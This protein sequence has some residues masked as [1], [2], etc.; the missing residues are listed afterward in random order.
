MRTDK[1][2]QRDPWMTM[3]VVLFLVVQAFLSSYIASAQA[4]PDA[5]DYY[6]NVICSGGGHLAVDSP[7]ERKH[8]PDCCNMNCGMFAAALEARQ[9]VSTSTPRTQPDLLRFFVAI[10]IFSSQQA[11]F[12]ISLPRAPPSVG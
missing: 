7:T 10:S 11:L 6:G 3:L 1:R 8:I 12:G 9:V 4:S 2:T 5:L